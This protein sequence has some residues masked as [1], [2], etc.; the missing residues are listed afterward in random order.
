MTRRPS[1]A[2]AAVLLVLSREKGEDCVLLTR[3]SLILREHAGEVALPG[4]KREAQD[5]SLYRTALRECHEEVG[6][7]ECAL[8]YQAELERQYTRQG[9]RVTP[10]VTA[11]RTSVPLRLCTQEIES[12]MWVPV[13]LFREDRRSA[14]HIFRTR[15][16]ELWS[17]VYHYEGYKIW[18]L[19]SRILV[20]FI[21]RYYGGQL[22]RAHVTAP[23]VVLGPIFT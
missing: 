4:G 5:S 2:D 18:G 14:T 9:A 8:I 6:I 10:F 20:S 21:N 16:A 7:S 22:Q 23:E 3:R 15:S 11:L 19:T 1:G 13:S 12:A 17:P